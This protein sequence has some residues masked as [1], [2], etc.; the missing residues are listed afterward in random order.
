[1]NFSAKMKS[2]KFW[3]AFQRRLSAKGANLDRFLK[4]HFNQIKTDIYLKTYDRFSH[5]PKLDH[6]K[7]GKVLT[8]FDRFIDN[9]SGPVCFGSPGTL[10][11]SYFLFPGLL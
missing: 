7:F 3:M 11:A 9:F 2:S 8:D 10:D 4:V 5:K 6:A 1:M